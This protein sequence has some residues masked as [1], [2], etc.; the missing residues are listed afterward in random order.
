MQL[1]SQVLVSKILV[2]TRLTRLRGQPG[3]TFP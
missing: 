1:P 2:A 3:Q